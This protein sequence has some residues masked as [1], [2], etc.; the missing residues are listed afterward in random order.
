MTYAIP[1]EVIGAQRLFATAEQAAAV[2]WGIAAMRYCVS[3]PVMD[4]LSVDEVE[5]WLECSLLQHPFF[6]D[7]PRR[8]ASSG[9]P[10]GIT[11]NCCRPVG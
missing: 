7:V 8:A 5:G 2:S 10:A 6:Q 9:S 3:E 4:A 1:R 11:E